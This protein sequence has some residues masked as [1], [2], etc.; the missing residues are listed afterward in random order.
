ME[1]RY[2]NRECSISVPD[3]MTHA[4]ESGIEFMAPISGA[5]FWSVSLVLNPTH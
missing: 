1:L 4:P 2:R 5:G 3:G